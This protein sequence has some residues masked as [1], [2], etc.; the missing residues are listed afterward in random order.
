MFILSLSA[1]V[2]EL[3]DVSKPL[4]LGFSGEQMHKTMIVYRNLT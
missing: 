3:V 1:G 4:N 2:D